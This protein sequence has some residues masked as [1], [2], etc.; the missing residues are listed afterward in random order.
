MERK[1]S[2]YIKLGIAVIIVLMI[3]VGNAYI[4]D[5]VIKNF[6]AKNLGYAFLRPKKSDAILPE[7]ILSEVLERENALLRKQLE[8]QTRSSPDLMLAKII[9]INRSAVVSSLRIDK[10]RADGIKDGMVVISGGNVLVGNVVDVT[11]HSAEVLL[12]DDPRSAISVRIHNSKI[13]AESRGAFGNLINLNLISQTE[14][15]DTESLIVTSGLDHFPEGLIIG[16]VR[17]VERGES[18]LFKKVSGVMS[19]DV[20]NGPT[21]FIIK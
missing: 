11:D 5:G 20:L 2:L 19:F 6:I 9:F 17:S 1:G 12:V 21:L 10:G 8:V 15:I 3:V 7:K 13:L 16:Q 18:Q 4:A 14:E